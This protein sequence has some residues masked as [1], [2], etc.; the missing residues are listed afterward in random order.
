MADSI[1]F[2]FGKGIKGSSGNWYKILQHLGTGGNSVVF[3]VLASDGDNQ[4]SLFALK[5]FRRLSI[6][7]RRNRFMKEI[8]FLVKCNHTSI[9]PIYDTGI[10]SIRG[11]E[12][13]F[14][15]TEYQPIT[16]THV[17]RAGNVSKIEKISYILQTLS[18]L[19]HLASQ[20]PAIVHRDVKPQNIFINGPS[21]M[22]GDF[23]LIKS[24]DGDEEEDRTL[25]G[26]SQEVAI[27]FS[28]RTPDLIS[29]AK[30]ESNITPKSDVFQL[31]VVAAELFT[32]WNPQIP[33]NNLL[34]PLKMKPIGTVAGKWGGQISNLINNMIVPDPN[35][36]PSANE[37]MDSWQGAFE[38]VA[39][40]AYAL[41]GHVFSRE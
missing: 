30:N 35:Q 8:A 19:K 7:S 1:Y 26:E 23:G 25:I 17:I 2:D 27:P 32:G 12:F 21:C 9:T 4:G 3:L 14:L 15:I 18:A 28:Y 36:R 24:I 31:G 10:Y 13:P 11:E 38:N 37:L 5:M 41:E 33:T 22:L 34:D 16:L 6:P 39:K 20:I 40:D 29:Y